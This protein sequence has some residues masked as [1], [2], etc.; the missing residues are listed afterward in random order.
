VILIFLQLYNSIPPSG[1]AEKSPEL[2][3]EQFCIIRYKSVFLIS[4]P[5][6]DKRVLSL[7]NLSKRF[8]IIHLNFYLKKIIYKPVIHKLYN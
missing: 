4:I 7:I 8:F 2:I 6:S 5:E 1:A 3:I